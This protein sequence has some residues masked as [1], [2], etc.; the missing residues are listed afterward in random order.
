MVD[1][2]CEIIIKKI[3]ISMPE[4]DDERAEIINYGL[5]NIIGEIPK[6]FLLIIIGFLLGIGKLTILSFLLILPYRTFAGGFHLKT[7]LGC[8]VGTTAMYCGNALLSKFIVLEPVYIKY[9]VIA[10]VWIFGMFMVKFYAPADTENVPILRKKDRKVKQIM[11]YVTLTLSLI[12]AIFIKSNEISN[13]IIFGTLIESLSIT[14]LAYKLTKNK[15]GYEVYNTQT[16]SNV[17]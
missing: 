12:V 14:R 10:S 1:K 4:I 15:Y 9:L 16:S 6:M 7:H 2:I 3:R 17:A 8:I 11:S 13:L 5:Q